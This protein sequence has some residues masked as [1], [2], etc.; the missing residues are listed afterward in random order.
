MLQICF[1]TDRIKKLHLPHTLNA[2]KRAVAPSCPLFWEVVVGPFNVGPFNRIIS[3]RCRERTPRFFAAYDEIPLQK[4]TLF[5]AVFC[6][7]NGARVSW[8]GF[9]FLTY[10]RLLMELLGGD[11]KNNSECWM[12][13]FFSRFGRRITIWRQKELPDLILLEERD[14]A[15]LFVLEQRNTEHR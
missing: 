10:N 7:R 12:T 9:L 5:P 2:Q 11:S 8:Q 4:W 1:P 6:W 13:D 15:V 14:L 3:E